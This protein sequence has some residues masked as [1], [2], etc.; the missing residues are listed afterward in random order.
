MFASVRLTTVT[1]EQLLTVQAND[2]D[3]YVML[4]IGRHSVALTREQ[5][6]QAADALRACA[7]T[8]WETDFTDIE[9][10]F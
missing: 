2:L 1:G 9:D 5:A 7:L 8:A 10:I 6:H 3:P 4:T